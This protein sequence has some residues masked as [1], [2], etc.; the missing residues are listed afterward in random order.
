VVD[1]PG[2]ESQLGK[3]IFLFYKRPDRLWGSPSLMLNGYQSYLEK[4][5]LLSR[6]PDHLQLV[7]R[8]RKSGTIPPLPLH[9]FMV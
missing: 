8:W 1:K 6:V 3:V 4:V 7:V 5:K 9:S 2:F